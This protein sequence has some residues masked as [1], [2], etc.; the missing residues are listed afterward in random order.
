MKLTGTQRGTAKG[1]LQIYCC[2]EAAAKKVHQL[3]YCGN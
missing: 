3:I 1:L 2:L